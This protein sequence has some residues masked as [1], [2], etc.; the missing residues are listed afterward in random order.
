MPNNSLK[1]AFRQLLR[2]RSYSIIN[3][4]GLAAGIAVCLLIFV[5]IRFETSFDD[6]HSK[7]D[8]IYRVMTEYHHPDGVFRGSA[9]PFPLP[10][11]IRREF[12]Q[13]ARTAGIYH[14][15]NAQVLV[16]GNDG[17][18]QKKFK[19]ATG[20]FN[21][22]PDFFSIFDF[23]WLAGSPAASLANPNS[24][25]LTRETAERYFG[26]WKDAVGR[27]IRV[28]GHLLRVTGILATI[29]PNTDFQ[30][31][32]VTPYSLTGIQN[33][34][35][36]GGTDESHGCYILLSPN[37]TAAS[38]E[39]PLRALIEKYRPAEDKDELTLGPLSQVHWF[40]AHAGNYSGQSVRSE[41]I[42]AL[43]LIGAFILLIACVNFINLA[44]ANSVNRAREVGVRK[45]L[46]GNMAELRR[47]FLLETFLIVAGAMVVAL[48]LARLALPGVASIVHLPLSGRML[49]SAPVGLFLAALGLVV[50]LLAGWY[51]SIVL[52]RFSPSEALRAKLAARAVKGI[53]LRRGLVVLQ[54]VIAQALIIGTLIMV[55]QMKFF[56]SEPM[57]FDKDAI[58]SV[59]FPTD[60]V[61]QTKYDYLRHRLAA[62][63]GVGRISL[64]S[65]GP[66]DQENSWTTVKFDHA[67]KE[68]DWFAINKWADSNYIGTYSIPLVAGTNFRANDSITEFLVT[69]R[70]VRQ[71]GLAHDVDAVGKEI[72]LWGYFKGPIVG[73]MKDF[74]ASSLKDGITPVM[75][76]KFKRG[77]GNAGIK[78]SNTD[79]PGT[80]KAIEKLWNEIYPNFVFEY[81]FLDERVA[82]FY[83][84]ESELSSLY[85]LFAGI[86]ILLSCLGLYGLAS[87][88]ATQRI[89]E[90]GIRKVLGA[91]AGRIL[92]LF[93]REFVILIG[94]AYLIAAPLAGWYMHGW[95]QDFTYRAPMSWWIFATGGILSVLVALVTVSLRA[96]RAATANPVKA[97]KTE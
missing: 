86:A 90:I 24:A 76:T 9:V 36:W 51:P 73:V 12:P 19:E 37:M 15:T 53:S 42:R 56:R 93:S 87:F 58:V 79:V 43:W 35:D 5:F 26:N 60:S 77:Y 95:L 68:T 3:I 72:N 49:F 46:G 13:L 27:S 38:L 14:S 92:L 1:T 52:S 41:V 22:E 31:K 39:R 20:V 10:T 83:K 59:P 4:S 8:R 61:A 63:P 55:R 50:T 7:K 33:Q 47:Q 94:V 82:E 44:T 96:M 54:F 6:F 81:Q 66:A 97:L 34:T 70:F 64:N 40:D 30:F 18:L 48:G 21:I 80:M 69:E 89:K 74:H 78:L 17:A 2:H 32:V 23:A 71:L 67:A 28:D 84:Q 11:M 16:M 45:V 29:P 57:G 25:V 85:Q 91:S 75:I 88:M 65:R 62:L